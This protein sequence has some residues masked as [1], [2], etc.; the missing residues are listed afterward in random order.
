MGNLSCHVCVPGRW[1]VALQQSPHTACL[2]LQIASAVVLRSAPLAIL[3][4]L[5]HI[6]QGL[7]FCFVNAVSDRAWHLKLFPQ[8]LWHTV[9]NLSVVSWLSLSLIGLQPQSDCTAVGPCC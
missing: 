8:G 2:A 7:G 5:T 3:R 6:F 9:E 1:P 4:G